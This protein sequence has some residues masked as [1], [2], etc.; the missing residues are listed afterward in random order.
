MS[1]S[2]LIRQLPAIPVVRD[3]SRAMAVLDAV[4]SPEWEFR[5]YSFDARWSPTEEMASMRDGSG[6]DYSIVFSSAG[7]YAR[8][9]DHESPMSPHRVT[10]PVPWPGLFDGLPKVFAHNVS[11]PAFTGHDGT[12]RVT[13]CFWR[14]QADARWTAGNVEALPGGAEHDGGAEW[15]FDVLADGRPE[16]YRRFAEDYYEV[17]VDIEAVRHVYAL[18]PLTQGV[19]SAL[20][21]DARL[22]DLAEDLRRIGY[23]GPEAGCGAA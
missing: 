15:L 2:E 22:A 9:F 17:T 6:G 1:I 4:M 16:A 23:P 20:N 10:P 21:P 3:C 8:G 5:H 11:E 12:P 7:A 13:V 14:E 18:R 19:V